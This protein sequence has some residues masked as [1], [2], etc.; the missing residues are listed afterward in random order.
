MTVTVMIAALLG[1]GFGEVLPTPLETPPF[2]YTLEDSALVFIGLELLDSQP[3]RV[4]DYDQWFHAHEWS[5]VTYH[6]GGIN[7]AIRGT[8]PP[9]DVDRVLRTPGEGRFHLSQ[10]IFGQEK[11]LVFYGD[12]PNRF[13]VVL[14]PRILGVLDPY[15][16]RP[17]LF[18]DF[19]TYS[20]GPDNLPQDIDFV[21]QQLRWAEVRDG[22]LYVSNAHRTYAESSGGFNAYLTAIDLETLEILWRSEPLVANAENFL[23]VGDTIIS[24]YGFTAEDDYVHLLNRLTGQVVESIAVPSAPEYLCLEGD[25]LFVRCYDTDLVFSVTR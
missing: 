7:D 3:N 8:T 4:T 18:L 1:T 24:G 19:L 20:E 2:S 14:D 23:L 16:L 15:S 12:E 5:A 22:I 21:F 11:T 10:I 17:E 25:R 13:G 6:N 9:A